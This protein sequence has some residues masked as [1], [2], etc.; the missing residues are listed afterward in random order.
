MS[1]GTL[2]PGRAKIDKPTLRT[3]RYWVSPLITF[4]IFIAFIAYATFRAFQNDHYYAS[5]YISPFY[6]P[7]ISD[8]CVPMQGAGE[9]HFIGSW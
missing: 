4:V 7:C 6:S 2:S 3:D 5:P 8:N 1:T 9:V